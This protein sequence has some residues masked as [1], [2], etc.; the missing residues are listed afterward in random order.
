M[1]HCEHYPAGA[2]RRDL[3]KALAAGAAGLLP[4]GA[5]LAQPKPGRR[6]R[7]DVHHHMLP[8]FQPNMGTRQYTPQ[9]SLDAMDKFGTEQA[10]LS[11]TIASD[12]LYD[13][14]E[15]ARKFAREANEYGAK[16]MQMHPWRLDSSPPC[17]AAISTRASRKSS[18]PSIRSSAMESRCSPIPATSGGVIQCSCPSL[19]SW[20]RRKSAV[21]FHPT[22]ANCCR[23][24][25][26]TGRRR[27]G[28]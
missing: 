12:Y 7:I 9:V 14:S 3:L 18:M 23:Q 1:N 22:V 21:F 19:M 25:G 11:L 27:G 10:I 28:I 8:P 20:N 2:S 26:R 13:G 15:K 6:G 17:R 16:A 4:A 5:L 24:P